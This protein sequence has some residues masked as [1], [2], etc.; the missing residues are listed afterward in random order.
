MSNANK[1]V[2]LNFVSILVFIFIFLCVAFMFQHVYRI[3]L[4]WTFNLK[5]HQNVKGN[6]FVIVLFEVLP[7]CC[8]EGNWNLCSIFFTV[9]CFICIKFLFPHPLREKKSRVAH[10]SR[11]EEK[12]QRRVRGISS[13]WW[14]DCV[15]VFIN[16]FMEE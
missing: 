14:V 15:F 13:G 7:P 2:S 16:Y 3:A 8:Y 4:H 5:S 11:N 10:V 6:F 12:E 9:L 1:K